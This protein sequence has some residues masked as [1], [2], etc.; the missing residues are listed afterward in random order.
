MTPVGLEHLPF[1]GCVIGRRAKAMRACSRWLSW[2]KEGFGRVTVNYKSSTVA[3]TR[4]A[5]AT[6]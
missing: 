4:V 3:E 5:V 1:H 6:L 2:A